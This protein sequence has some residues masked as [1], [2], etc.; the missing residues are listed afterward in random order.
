QVGWLGALKNLP[1]V[2]AELT[3]GLGQAA[4]VA[5][6]TTSC[7]KFAS[8]VDH[9]DGVAPRQ[10]DKLLDDAV[11]EGVGLDR[12]RSGAPP[13]QVCERGFT[14]ALGGGIQDNDSLL[15]RLRRGRDIFRV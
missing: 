9:G 5:H 7:G 15:E 10:R 12:E 1:G 13:G 6:E 11:E 3:I 14:I 4:S 2:D 8:R